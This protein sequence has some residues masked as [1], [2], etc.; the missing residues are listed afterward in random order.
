MRAANKHYI[1]SC[2]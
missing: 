1:V 2:C